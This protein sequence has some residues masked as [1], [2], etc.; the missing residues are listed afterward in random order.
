[1]IDIALLFAWVYKP[2]HKSTPRGTHGL[3]APASDP[4]Y[5]LF[6]V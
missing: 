6:T 4:V 1:M 3:E 5:G 2:Q